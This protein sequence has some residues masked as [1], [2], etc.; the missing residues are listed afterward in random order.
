MT[1]L[2]KMVAAYI[3]SASLTV[4]FGMGGLY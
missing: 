3:A 2:K 1:L 4:P